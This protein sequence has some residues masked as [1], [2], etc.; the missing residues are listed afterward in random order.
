VPVNVVSKYVSVFGERLDGR[1]L[2][3]THES[4]IS[5]RICSEDSGKLA[6]GV[7]HDDP[8]R[9]FSSFH[10]G[11]PVQHVGAALLQ[12]ETPAFQ[13]TRTLRDL[14]KQLIKYTLMP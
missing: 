10:S 13:R 1:F 5:C 4:R 11:S 3:I 2:I 6:L 7:R 12:S 8:Y 9:L 14:G